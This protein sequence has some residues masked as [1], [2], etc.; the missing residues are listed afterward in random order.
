MKR[1]V[2]FSSLIAIVAFM[3]FC[4]AS[5][6]ARTMTTKAQVSA[7]SA[8]TVLAQREARRM[9]VAQAVLKDRINARKL[10]VGDKF[11]A[12][13]AATVHLKNGLKLPYGTA[14]IGT[15]ATD[16]M[17]ADG[18]STLALRFTQAKLKNGKVVPI[19]ATIVEV[20]QPSNPYSSWMSYP[21]ATYWTDKTLRIDQ[22][23]AESGV[24]MHSSIASKNSAVFVTKKK[25]DVNLPAGEQISLAIAARSAS[26]HHNS[27]ET[28][29]V[30]TAS[31]A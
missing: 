16:K 7:N 31:G 24:N 15:V 20:A 29:S 1:E 12:T 26:H 27:A 14:L 5:S 13:L 18:T 25:D 4:P 10:N 30:G 22:I 23:S 9:V 21:A 19:K 6:Q 17:Q 28:G 8:T 11:Q 3:L 2:L